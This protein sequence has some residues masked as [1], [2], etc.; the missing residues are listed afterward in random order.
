MGLVQWG[1]IGGA[2]TIRLIR[3]RFECQYPGDE[4]ERDGATYI[5]GRELGRTSADVHKAIIRLME[6]EFFEVPVLGESPLEMCRETVRRLIV[7]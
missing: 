3:V 2:D 4:C 7:W 5:A 1:S 6:K